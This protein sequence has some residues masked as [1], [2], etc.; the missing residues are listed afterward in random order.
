MSH[1]TP[2][3]ADPGINQPLIIRR[4]RAATIV[5]RFW[6]DEDHTVE[7]A[8]ED[9]FRFILKPMA[10]SSESDA[11]IDITNATSLVIDGNEIRVPLTV[12]NSDIDRKKCYY[13]LINT[14]TDQNWF[15]DYVQI[16]SGSAPESSTVTEAD[17]QIN[18]GDNVVEVNISVM[19]FDVNTL[20]DAQKAALW[21]AL[22]PY[23]LGEA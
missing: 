18:V 2:L 19:G 17:G 23:S 10:E 21:A 1:S 3:K 9:D 8:I 12:A 22:A 20:T 4:A 13:E 16:I 14:T 7:Y 11:L 5:F 15:Q 6:T